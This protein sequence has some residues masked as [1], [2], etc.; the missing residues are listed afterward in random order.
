MFTSGSLCVSPELICILSSNLQWLTLRLN[1]H[2]FDVCRST[3]SARTYTHFYFDQ[4]KVR[5]KEN[6]PFKSR[7]FFKQ[8]SIY[9]K[10][11]RLKELFI[12]FILYRNPTPQLRVDHWAHRFKKASVCSYV[13]LFNIHLWPNSKN[14]C[15]YLQ[16][17]NIFY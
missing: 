8:I 13:G 2:L 3:C 14:K 15:T 10:T 4:N 6:I 5:Q 7:P 1:G 16:T 12:T 11:F 17:T 9:P